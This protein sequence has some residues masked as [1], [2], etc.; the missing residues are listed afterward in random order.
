MAIH[1]HENKTCSKGEISRKQQKI[2][3]P[4]NSQSTEIWLDIAKISTSSEAQ[5]ST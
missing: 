1:F 4:G 2:N 5:K 3:S